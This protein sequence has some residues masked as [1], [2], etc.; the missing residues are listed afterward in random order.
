MAY[1]LIFIRQRLK[2]AVTTG[3]AATRLATMH[4]MERRVMENGAI[5]RSVISEWPLVVKQSE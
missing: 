1:L 3:R 2:N 5:E 4:C